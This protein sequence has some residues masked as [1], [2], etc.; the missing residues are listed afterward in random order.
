[1]FS[2]APPGTYG[3]SGKGELRGPYFEDLVL[4]FAKVFPITERQHLQVRFEM[5]NAGSTW[6]HGAWIPCAN[7][8]SCGTTPLGSLVPLQSSADLVSASAW[9]RDNLW[10]GHTIQLSAVY[11]F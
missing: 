7:V 1:V 11:S 3:D 9:A 4:S 10:Q 8:P 6:H 5:F 2:L